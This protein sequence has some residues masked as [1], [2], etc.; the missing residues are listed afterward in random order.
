VRLVLDASAAV[1]LVTRAEGAVQLVEHVDAAAERFSELKKAVSRGFQGCGGAVRKTAV[2][3]NR[4]VPKPF[5][6]RETGARTKR[7]PEKAIA[8]QCSHVT[9]T[10]EN[11]DAGRRC[12][13]SPNR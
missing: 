6:G 13:Q 8:L 10:G 11:R 12:R 5:R 3:P 4:I 2:L 9:P 7:G 1:R